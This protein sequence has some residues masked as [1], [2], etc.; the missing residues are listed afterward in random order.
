MANYDF[1][2]IFKSTMLRFYGFHMMLFDLTLIF[3]LMSYHLRSL[4][5]L[6]IAMVL[7]IPPLVKQAHTNENP[8]LVLRLPNV[9]PWHSSQVF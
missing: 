2:I 3:L 1:I 4:V 7:T 6:N 5:T 9:L 8:T